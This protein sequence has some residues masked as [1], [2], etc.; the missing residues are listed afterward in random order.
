MYAATTKNSC[1]ARYRKIHLLWFWQM[2]IQIELGADFVPVWEASFLDSRYVAE[3][4][5]ARFGDVISQRE[6]NILRDESELRQNSERD[7]V[8]LCACVKNKWRLPENIVKLVF[9]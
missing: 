3:Q 8:Q 5:W 7:N 6:I 9:T 4:I 2:S 1:G